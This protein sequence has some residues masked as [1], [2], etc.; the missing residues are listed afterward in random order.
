MPRP[1]AVI[2]VGTSSIR[3]AIAEILDDGRLHPLESL[4][5]GLSLGKETFSK[6][7]ISRAATEDAVRV[8]R[9]FRIKLDEYSVRV[10][11]DVRV[12]ATSAVREAGNKLAFLDRVFIATGL[13][14]E[15]IDEAEVHRITY[16]GVRPLLSADSPLSESNVLVNEA[17]GGS[18]ELLLFSGGDVVHAKS[19]R[20]G[21]LRLR[22]QLQRLR[23]NPDRYRS[24]MR[25]QIQQSIADLPDD[26]ADAFPNAVL[27]LGGDLRF[28]AREVLGD[29][30]PWTST[31]VPVA[32]LDD[33][34][35]EILGLTDAEIVQ[36]F[37]RT[38]PE[39]ETLGAA[40]LVDVEIAK[41]FGLSEVIV[42]GS[43]LRD[44]LLREMAAADGWSEDFR[45]QVLVSA[46]ALG[47]RFD[48]DSD[49]A[50]HVSNLAGQ[51]FRELAREHRLDD[52][53]ETLL[54]TAALL[55]EVGRFVGTSG[56]HKHSMYLIQHS[57]LFGLPQRDKVLVALTARYHRRSSP[58]SR[59]PIYG[60]LSRRDRSAVIKMA[61]LLRVAIALDAG[62]DG[63][64]REIRCDA[65]RDRII[66]KVPGRTDLTTEQLALDASGSLFQATF[67]R[68]VQLR[69]D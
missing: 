15:A 33:L 16:R 11:D 9:T 41:L 69:A 17:G 19:L 21:G 35:N 55:Y 47:K 45:R 1:I 37:R 14:I 6:G 23:S 32:D 13:P 59:H 27:A 2:D 18:T 68:P 8:L 58:K 64:V 39:A 50:E 10:P 53:H 62:R 38:F 67:G 7:S 63:T 49:H 20:L 25:R 44:G 31:Q 42:S 5:H 52:R 60:T 43:T 66:V 54:Q 28:A 48:Y 34:T 36:R 24:E 4:S 46:R 40:L 30:N 65:R 3:M 22:L 61:S 29:Y 56:I 26:F 12:V 57:D 51:L